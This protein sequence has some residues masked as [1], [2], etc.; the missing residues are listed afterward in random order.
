[1]KNLYQD[2][3][4]DHYH[5]P[6]YQKPLSV[7]DFS[8]REANPSCGDKVLVEGVV[9]DNILV[10][11]Y[12]SGSGCV[13][14]QAATSMVLERCVGASVDDILSLG[15]DDACA[16]I[17]MDLGPNRLRCAMLGLSALQHGIQEVKNKK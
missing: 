2:I 7:P 8:C 5:A 6:R 12:F 3:L 1:M 15:A 13:L 4:L 14:S 17:G 11:A 10:D 9:K 16:L